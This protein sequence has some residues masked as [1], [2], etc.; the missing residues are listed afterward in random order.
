M[1]AYFHTSRPPRARYHHLTTDQ[2]NRLNKVMRTGTQ[3]D[4]VRAARK[5]GLSPVRAREAVW[6]WRL[7]RSRR[8]SR[9]NTVTDQL[10]PGT[11]S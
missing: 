3:A 4:I 5:L 1:V 7:D 9:P 11:H 10:V 8:E 6:R 2:L